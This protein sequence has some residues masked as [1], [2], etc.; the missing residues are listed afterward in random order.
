MNNNLYKEILREFNYGN[1]C[2][3]I[4]LFKIY[5]YNKNSFIDDHIL[6]VYTNSLINLGFYYE[7]INN[8]KILCQMNNS[9]KNKFNLAICY[10]KVND[11]DNSI[12]LFHELLNED[13]TN[14]RIYYYIAKIHMLNGNYK[15]AKEILMNKA[16]YFD[17]STKD[18]AHKMLISIDKHLIYGTSIQT[19]YDVFKE[20][21]NQLSNGHI[22]ELKDYSNYHDSVEYFEIN[23]GKS[24]LI[25]RNNKN[26]YGFL[27]NSINTNNLTLENITNSFIKINEKDISSVIDKIDDE[28]YNQLL[29][30]IYNKIFYAGSNEE[31]SKYAPFIQGMKNDF[32]ISE[33][34]VIA[35]RSINNEYIY[36]FITRINT[37]NN[38]K[39]FQVSTNNEFIFDLKSKNPITIKKDRNMF[40]VIKIDN[41]EKRKLYSQIPECYTIDTL[42]GKIVKLDTQE[43]IIL[44]KNNNEYIC[45]DRI[46][47]N[48]FMNISIIPEDSYL[49]IIDTLEKDEYLS[50]LKLF[51]Q[52]NMDNSK[53]GRGKIKLKLIEEK[54]KEQSE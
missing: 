7:A 46:F 42:E 37:D 34:D 5:T 45:I 12:K 18:D 47:S 14:Y 3:V 36:Y 15:T 8:L 30:D 19:N 26:I 17:E 33:G 31:K 27:I 11:Y 48:S 2:E 16:F 25:W 43:M 49:T 9:Y 28:K 20:N 52:N 35:F 1:Y 32:D 54:I 51:Y 6:Y 38:Y 13:P 4:K 40:K 39:A 53:I 21:G 10:S 29:K 41:M 24:Y 50:I 23:N 44:I 22:V